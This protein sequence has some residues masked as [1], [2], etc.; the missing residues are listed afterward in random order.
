[1]AGV[2]EETIN[3]RGETMPTL[4]IKRLGFAMATTGVLL[5]AGCVF[6]MAT[7]P[8]DVAVR[9]F[10]SLLHGLDV[11]PIAGRCL[12]RIWLLVWWRLLSWDGCSEQQSRHCTISAREKESSMLNRCSPVDADFLKAPGTKT[13]HCLSGYSKLISETGTM[14][15]IRNPCVSETLTVRLAV[16]DSSFFF[17]D[18]L[19][20]IEIQ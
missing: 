3:E 11:G 17:L 12:G 18:I 4:S 14:G 15:L 10:N 20:Q 8:R 5:Y 2:P 19:T 1:M 7:V 9:F 13:R 6:V 16:I